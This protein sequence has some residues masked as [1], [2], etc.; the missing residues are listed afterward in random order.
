MKDLRFCMPENAPFFDILHA[1]RTPDN[2]LIH[3]LTVQCGEHHVEALSKALSVILR[4]RGSSL[5]LPR[6]TLGNLTVEQ[7]TKYF[8][9]HENY[10]KSLRMIVLASMIENIDKEREEVDASSG[11]TQHR[12]TRDWATNLIAPST[13]K[14]AR[15]DIVNGGKKM[16]LPFWYLV[17]CILRFSSKSPSIRSASIRRLVERYAFRKMLLASRISFRSTRRSKKPWIV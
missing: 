16:L 17:I 6:M 11:E 4:G 7:H 10:M 14:C 5:Y 13:C 8:Q 3:H 2:Q 15:C 1:K 9:S 12:T